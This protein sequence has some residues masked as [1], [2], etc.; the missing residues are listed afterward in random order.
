MGLFAFLGLF[1]TCRNRNAP[2]FLFSRSSC[3]HPLLFHPSWIFL[4]DFLLH[5]IATWCFC[6]GV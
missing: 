2:S 3:S 1:V 6:V 5:Y 4:I